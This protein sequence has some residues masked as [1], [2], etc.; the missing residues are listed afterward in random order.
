[1]RDASFSEEHDLSYAD[2]VLQW[3]Y[4]TFLDKPDR[5]VKIPGSINKCAVISVPT[6][7]ILAQILFQ[8]D[9]ADNPW[10]AP[11]DSDCR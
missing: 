2:D 7:L 3:M 6:E 1:M 10:S 8:Y 9:G 11:R 4:E 5:I